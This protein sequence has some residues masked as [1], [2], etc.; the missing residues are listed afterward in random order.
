MASLRAHLMDPPD[1]VL[2]NRHAHSVFPKPGIDARTATKEGIAIASRIRVV[3]ALAGGVG[4]VHGGTKA[5]FA[6][7][8]GGAIVQHGYGTAFLKESAMHHILQKVHHLAF[9]SS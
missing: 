1:G 9:S 6:F 2:P 8:I 3:V 7:F 4:P 5:S